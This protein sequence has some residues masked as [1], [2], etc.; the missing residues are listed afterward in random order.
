MGNGVQWE[1]NRQKIRRTK[2]KY[3]FKGETADESLFPSNNIGP[4]YY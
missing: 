1:N 4:W 3:M 2:I